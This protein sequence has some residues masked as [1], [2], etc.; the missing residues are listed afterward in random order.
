V[1]GIASETGIAYKHVLTIFLL[2]VADDVSSIEPDDEAD[3]DDDANGKANLE[4]ISSTPST[5]SA[6]EVETIS[7]KTTKK[8]TVGKSRDGDSMPVRPRTRRQITESSSVSGQF[9][10]NVMDDDADSANPEGASSQ[11]V[12]VLEGSDS[13]REV[14]PLPKTNVKKVAPLA[15]RPTTRGRTAWK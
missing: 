14:Q 10:S 7:K 3:D 1:F 5:R 2:V 15:K 9:P 8:K 6:R 4:P 13:D 11:T 12:V